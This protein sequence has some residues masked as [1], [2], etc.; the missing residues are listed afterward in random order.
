MRISPPQLTS[1]LPGVSSLLKVV[2]PCL[3]DLSGLD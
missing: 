3:R 1:K 2:Y